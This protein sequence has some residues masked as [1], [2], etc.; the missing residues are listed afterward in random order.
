VND[1]GERFGK[2]DYVV[3]DA[4]RNGMKTFLRDCESP[5]E[6]AVAVDTN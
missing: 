3:G 5:G 4:V 6:T 1:H 2:G